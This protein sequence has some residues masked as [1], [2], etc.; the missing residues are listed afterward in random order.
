MSGRPLNNALHFLA[1]ST[2]ERRAAFTLAEQERESVRQGQLAEQSSLMHDAEERIRIWERL[3]MVKLPSKPEHELVYV[4][5][6][7]TRLTVQEVQQEQQR[8]V[9]LTAAP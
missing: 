3:H 2:A 5:A 9:L 1:S 7:Q 6:F 4:I 8:R